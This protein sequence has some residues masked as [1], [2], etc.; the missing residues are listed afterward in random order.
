MN[1]RNLYSVANANSVTLYCIFQNYCR[2]SSPHLFEIICALFKLYRACC[3]RAVGSP[4][5]ELN[6]RLSLLIIHYQKV[7]ELN[8]KLP[9]TF[10]NSFNCDHLIVAFV[11]TWLNPGVTYDEVFYFDFQSFRYGVHK[12]GGG[13]LIVV[14]ISFPSY[15]FCF[16]LPTFSWNQDAYLLCTYNLLLHTSCLRHF[17]LLRVNVSN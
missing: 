15:I 4:F 3:I 7:R 14:S 9:H 10:V 6:I 5:K 16:I 8:M 1:L 13:V 12:T 11:K 2:V 17:R